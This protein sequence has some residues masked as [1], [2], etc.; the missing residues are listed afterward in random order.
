MQVDGAEEEL[1]DELEDICSDDGEVFIRTNFNDADSAV[2]SLTVCV[3]C[4]PQMIQ[5]APL[6]RP[7][8]SS[9]GTNTT[10]QTLTFSLHWININIRMR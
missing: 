8:S 7:S 2:S 6:W 9:L 1:P 4:R 3:L 5:T 10:A